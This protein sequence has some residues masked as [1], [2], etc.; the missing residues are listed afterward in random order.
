MIVA[1]VALV[2]LLAIPAFHPRR[3]QVAGHA[4]PLPSTTERI[5]VEVLNG[6]S[7]QGL[8]RIGTRVLR[9]QGFDVVFFGTAGSR[10]DS[11]RVIIRRGSRPAGEAVARALGARRITVEIDTLRR[12]D[13]TVILGEDFRPPPDWHP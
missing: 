4:Y 9:S 11:T 6:T 7:R 10:M 2:T 13:V 3:D 1:G 5:M 8:A 12:V